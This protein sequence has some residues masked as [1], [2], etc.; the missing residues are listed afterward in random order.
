M[1]PII[2]AIIVENMFK[3][4]PQVDFTFSI[5][6]IVGSIALLVSAFTFYISYTQASQSE[7][8]K[9]SRDL[10]AG[11]KD[12]VRKFREDLANANWQTKNL[13]NVNPDDVRDCISE[14]E[15]F[16]YLITKG[17]INDKMVLGYYKNLIADSLKITFSAYSSYM[18]KKYEDK[19]YQPR[20]L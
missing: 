17:E 6:D 20:K 5:G 4:L 14:I 18:D 3:Q 12:R 15:Y 11:I 1:L 8:I 13:E 16:A 10:W 2:F 9:T 7:Q 19:A